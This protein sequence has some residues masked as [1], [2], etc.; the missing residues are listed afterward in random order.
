MEPVRNI[1][2]C[3]RWVPMPDLIIDALSAS[4]MKGDLMSKASLATPWLLNRKRDSWIFSGIWRFS[5]RKQRL[6][7]IGICQG[8]LQRS[9]RVWM[10]AVG[11]LVTTLINSFIYSFWLVYEYWLE[12][13][14]S[15]STV[16]C[17]NL[18][19]Y[20]MVNRNLSALHASYLFR[21][22]WHVLLGFSNRCRG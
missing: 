14:F 2:C 4:A 1:D 7:D 18:H 22:D 12:G 20:R 15:F 17:I 8:L 10:L 11:L 13:V 16:T 9:V 3:W 6:W 19:W 21:R 5:F